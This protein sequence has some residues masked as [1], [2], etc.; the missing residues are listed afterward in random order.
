MVVLHHALEPLINEQAHVASGSIAKYTDVLT[1]TKRSFDVIIRPARDED[2]YWHRSPSSN[3]VKKLDKLVPRCTVTFIQCIDDQGCAWVKLERFHK[4][5][6][7]YRSIKAAFV[8]LN[9]IK[10]VNQA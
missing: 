3:T 1:S 6:L 9:P 5:R 10:G 4:Q 7:A 8:F 2:L